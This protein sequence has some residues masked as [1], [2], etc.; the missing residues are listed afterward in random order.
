MSKFNSILRLPQFWTWFIL[1]SAIVLAVEAFLMGM[2]IL[3]IFNIRVDYM[4][5]IINYDYI[6][7]VFIA[8]LFGLSISL[9]HLMKKGGALACSLSG[10]AGFGTFITLLCPVCP[11]FI[12]A[13]FGLSGGL[14]FISFL[15]PYFWWVRLVAAIILLLS[16][17]LIYRQIDAKKLPIFDGKTFWHKAAMILIISLFFTNQSLAMSLGNKLLNA[18]ADGK[19]VMSGEFSHDVYA[20]VVPTDIPFYGNK[21]GLD[22][23]SINAINKSIAIL[24]DFAPRQGSNPIELS[25]KEFQRYVKIGTEPT[26]TCEFCCG[27]K[28]LVTEDGEPTCGCAHSIAMRGTIA[29]LISNYSDMTDAEIAYEIIRQKGLFFPKQMQERMASQLA[30]DPKDFTPDIKYLT[31][32]LKPQEIADFKKKAGAKGFKPQGPTMVGGC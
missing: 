27:V 13:F 31:K 25:E 3:P 14:S 12:F 16:I 28:T 18:S 24:S 20:L 17:V 23:S 21:L 4:N 10:F 22:Y 1:S 7:I 29:Y 9:F 2:Y 19:V 15:A 32:N 5:P 6:F 30:G 8:L 11:L 26:V